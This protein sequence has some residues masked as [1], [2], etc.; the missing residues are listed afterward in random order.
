MAITGRDLKTRE[1]KALFI[2]MGLRNCY[3]EQTHLH[4]ALPKHRGAANAVVHRDGNN[5][6]IS[7][8]ERR[9]LAD[10]KI[11]AQI[12]ENDPSPW[13]KIGTFRL[14]PSDHLNAS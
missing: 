14:G 5:R 4:A 8:F 1:K 7:L 2:T 11:L 3:V 10:K 9:Y 12:N 13:S 6:I